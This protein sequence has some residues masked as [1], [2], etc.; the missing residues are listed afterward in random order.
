MKKLISKSF[1]ALAILVGAVS[2]SAETAVIVH[3]SNNSALSEDIIADIY[4]GKAKKFPNGNKVT[5]IT[6]SEKS[7]AK[8]SFN[9]KVLDKSNSQLK[10]Y[11]AKLVF[12]GKGRPP[13]EHST[14]EEVKQLVATNPNMIGV[15]D[16]GAVDA[17]VKVVYKF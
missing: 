11:W 12:T 16:A 10:T 5:A 13:K 6:V 2:V 9:K 3:T 8:T 14:D 17:S 7:D 1:V 4:L 15:I